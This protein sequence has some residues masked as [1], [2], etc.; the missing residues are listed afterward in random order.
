MEIAFTISDRIDPVKVFRSKAE[1]DGDPMAFR[2]TS[3]EKDGWQRLHVQLNYVMSDHDITVEHC[4]YLKIHGKWII[5]RD[6][7]DVSSIIASLM[8]ETVR[9]ADPQVRLLGCLST[10]TYEWLIDECKKELLAMARR[11]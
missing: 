5:P 6:L 10:H 7:D 9:L 3:P 1:P 8:M 2:L 11:P 4:H